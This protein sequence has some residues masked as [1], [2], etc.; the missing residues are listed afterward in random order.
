MTPE[1]KQ[2]IMNTPIPELSTDEV[3]EGIQMIQDELEDHEE[4]AVTVP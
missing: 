4:K 3:A 2:R 1:K